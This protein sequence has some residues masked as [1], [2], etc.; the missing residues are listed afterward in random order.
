MSRLWLVRE[1]YDMNMSNQRPPVSRRSFLTRSAALSTGTAAF[2]IVKPQQVRGAGKARLKAGLIGCGGR[3]TAAVADMLLGTENV[4]FVAMAD[5]FEDQLEGSLRRLRDPKF[6][7][8]RS[9]FPVE[10]DGKFRELTKEEIGALPGRVKVGPEYRYTGFDAYKKLI[11]SDVDIVMLATPP[12]WRPIHFEAAV[13]A[14]KHVFAEK[15]F[16][17]DP[18]GIRRFMAAARKSEQLKL[19]VMAGA[20]R[21]SHPG[22]VAQ[23]KKFHN[24]EMGEILAGYAWWL[25]RPVI[26]Q[27]ARNTKWADL[28]WQHRNWYSYVWLCGDQ[29]VEQEIHNIDV[30]NWFFNAHPVKVM[31]SG[32]CIWR[33][34]NNE[35][36]GNIYDHLSADFVYPNGAHMTSNCRQY[37]AGLPGGNGEIIVGSKG[38]VQLSLSDDS[39]PHPQVNEHTEMLKSIRGEGPYQNRA[40][41]M[42]ESTMTAVMGRE[43]AYSGMEITWDMMMNSKLDLM[44][45]AF[46][47]DASFPATPL[48]IP[49][50]YKFI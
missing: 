46:G 17:T 20:Q 38:R 48:P 4:D 47:L 36:Y 6:L 21:R 31:A 35:V 18:V 9:G 11:S 37:P 2:T 5:L 45:K 16:G 3:G 43:A 29:I 42:A 50:E 19:T 44:P 7:A 23:A 26:K 27:K 32:G 24:G 8:N 33:P 25:G 12:G 30:I 22:Y 34:R 13:E 14:K 40:M 39:G 41:A 49:G 10:R 15:P 28:E 1:S